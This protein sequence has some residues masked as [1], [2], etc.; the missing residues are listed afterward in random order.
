M[1]NNV[2]RVLECY[3]CIALHTTLLIIKKLNLTDVKINQNELTFVIV[4]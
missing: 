4:G 2:M 3:D 1:L